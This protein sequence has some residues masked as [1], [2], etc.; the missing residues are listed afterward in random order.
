MSSKILKEIQDEP[1]RRP[2][3]ARVD[4]LLGEDVEFNIEHPVSLLSTPSAIVKMGPSPD[5]P[6]GPFQQLKKIRIEI[7]G[8]AEA[9]EAETAGLNLATAL[10]WAAV[11]KRF[12]MRLDYHTPLPCT[13]YDRTASRG[14]MMI[15]AH[16]RCYWPLSVHDFAELLE[17]DIL[18]NQTPV[19]RQLLLSMEL[20]AATRLE[21][22][23]RTRFISLVSSLE[24]LAIPFSY[25]LSIRNLIDT[26]RKQVKEAEFPELSDNACSRLKDSLDRRLRDLQQDSI[27]QAILRLVRELLPGDNNAVKIIDDAYS[28]RSSILHEGASDPYLD[29][30]VIYVEDTI[31]KIYA[32]RIGKKLRSAPLSES[33]I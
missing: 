24:P 26:F 23:E 30:K 28:L 17:E 29:R 16:G 5:K 20:F 18:K 19:D 32:S 2:Y 3:A 6:S 7:E 10:L 12:A 22:S 14:G 21:I 15:R 11:S 33:D 31:R 27:R 8:Y 13:V 4:F 9:S 1:R 25:P